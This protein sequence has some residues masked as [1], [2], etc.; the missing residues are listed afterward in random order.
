MQHKLI[1]QLTRTVTWKTGRK[2]AKSNCVLLQAGDI[3]ILSTV[4]RENSHQTLHSKIMIFF[5]IL[6]NHFN[7]FVFDS[8]NLY[9][10]VQRIVN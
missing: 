5:Q 1:C 10:P 7:I 6:L 2:T 3:K 9:L 8:L 4:A